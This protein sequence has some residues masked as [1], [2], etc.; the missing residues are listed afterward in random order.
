MGMEK[1][2]SPAAAGMLSSARSSS[3]ISLRESE[4]RMYRLA[5]LASDGIIMLDDSGT[6][7]FANASAESMF[8]CS[9]GEMAGRDFHRDF[10]P[11]ELSA[12]AKKG[13]A[14]FLQQGTG[15]LIGAASEVTALHRD[16]SRFPLELSLSALKTGGTWHAIGIMRDV[17]QGKLLEARTAQL[18][19]SERFAADV[20]DSLTANIAVLDCNGIIVAVNRSWQR[21]SSENCG[22]TPAASSVG[23][24]YLSFCRDSSGTDDEA[25]LAASLGISSVLKGDQSTFSLEYPC[26][27]PDT[28][29]W[30][31]M[32]VSRLHGPLPGVVV[33][34]TDITAQK[35]L[36]R[37]IQDAREYA[38]NIVETVREPLVVLNR[39]LKIL[40]ANQS[41]YHTF[42]VLPG[43]TIGQF[44]YDL[45][46]RQ[47]DIPKLR[48]LFEEILPHDTVFNGYE[49]E[50]NF[51][52]IGRKTILLNARQIFRENIG[53]HIIL[54]AMEDITERKA[55]EAEIRDAREYAENIVEAVRE[56]LVV[57]DCNLK[58][59]TA[60][61]SFYRTFR[62]LP[63]ATIGKFIYDLGNG[64]WDIPKLRVLFEEILPHDTV[65]NDYEVEHN[66]VGIGRKTILLN[67]RQIFRKNVGSHIILLAMRDITERREAETASINALKFQQVL[68]DAIP[69]P[70]FFKNAERVYIGANKAFERYLGLPADRFIGKSVFEIASPDL[71]L[72]YDA[73][74]LELLGN[75]GVQT[76]QA[77]VLYADGLRHHV[78]FN[79]ATFTDAAGNLAGLVGVILDITPQHVAEGK[80]LRAVEE[81]T[82]AHAASEV[83]SRAKSDFLA[84]MS[85]ELRTPL[86]A[87]IGFSE[88]LLARMFGPVNDKQQEYIHFIL[89]GG[90]HL[91][92]LINDILDLSKVEAGKMELE[93]ESFPLKE[94]LD[95]S[96]ALLREKAQAGGVGLSPASAPGPE[97]PVAADR[98]KLK[99]IMFNLLSNAIKFTPRGG[100]V[101]VSLQ[102]RDGW[103]T[104]SVADTGKGIKAEDIPKLF[105]PFTQLESAYTKEYEGTGLGL[106]LTRRL[107]ELHG[108][109]IWVESEFGLGSRFSFTLP[110]A[111][112]PLG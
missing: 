45:G 38:E 75:P 46:N 2:E 23:K 62:V 87:V 6:V 27:S 77:S 74:D 90:R 58:V 81:I 65:F 1:G 5:E 93:L 43:E 48:V 80:L 15:P 98:R 35:Q 21:F 19:E 24:D 92:S 16:G 76:Y 4:A 99:Q 105:Q 89:D 56:P 104:V 70:V 37:E 68:M 39:E 25:G 109:R 31:M 51:N 17:S 111:P 107:V 42:Q 71:A 14:R 36:E 101:R 60:N 103:V 52:D 102:E 47:W 59:L 100:A 106:A 40:T 34:H 10:I 9:A 95:A 88:V 97:Y 82:V 50:H 94:C 83:A 49:V 91:L 112:P 73:S 22:T 44:I 66:F 29:R 57:L 96:L 13:F 85:H 8:G 110:L 53:S 28:K 86:N 33:S 84:N 72:V 78:V 7:T 18:R 55:L 11:G 69:S 79:K 20:M 61:G 108:G 3:G 64:Q 30:F 12:A 41:F 67:G 63:E 32:S 26:H 54:L